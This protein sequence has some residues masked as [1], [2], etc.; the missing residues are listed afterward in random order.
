MAFGFLRG[1]GRERHQRAVDGVAGDRGELVRHDAVARHEGRL[2]A[3]V[4]QLAH[5]Q[6]GFRVQAAVVDDRNA[7]FLHLGD[8]RREVLVADI[9]AFIHGFGDAGRV[10]RLLGFVGEALAVRGLV[11]D[12]RD[13]GVLEVGGEIAAGHCALLV[14]A[15]AGAERVP[16]AA[17]G[18]LRVGCRR[19]DDENAVLGID[20]RRRDGDARVEVADHELDAVSDELVGDRDALLRIGDVVADRRARSS[21]R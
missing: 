5:D 16:Q 11:M 10:E 3:L 4:G 13:L 8:Q 20:V 21:R 6:A 9:D 1:S 2:Q 18:E 17:L 14:V 19:R 7:G 15:S 12:D